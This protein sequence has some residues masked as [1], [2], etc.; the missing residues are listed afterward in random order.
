MRISAPSETSSIDA[1][2][3]AEIDDKG[4]GLQLEES[5][6]ST[7]EEVKCT[8]PS[9]AVQTTEPTELI[10]DLGG[11]NIN[12]DTGPY[13]YNYQEVQLSGTRRK[14]CL[15]MDRPR[16]VVLH[17]E[18]GPKRYTEKVKAVT[19]SSTVTG[20]RK[21]ATTAE[22]QRSCA[23]PRGLGKDSYRTAGPNDAADTAKCR[24]AT[25]NKIEWCVELKPK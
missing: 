17:S 3:D 5:G 7:A 20:D 1:L 6:R 25:H 2:I 9:P 14:I 10:F 24:V 16:T 21:R 11:H 15:P 22:S 19:R 18:I 13:S 4:L 23:A 8:P 12:P